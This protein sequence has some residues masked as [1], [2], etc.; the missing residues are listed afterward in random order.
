MQARRATRMAPS[1]TARVCPHTTM[2]VWTDTKSTSSPIDMQQQQQQQRHCTR[3]QPVIETDGGSTDRPAAW[4]ALASTSN[5]IRQHQCTP[6]TQQRRAGFPCPPRPLPQRQKSPVTAAAEGRPGGRREGGRWVGDARPSLAWQH[7]QEERNSIVPSHGAGHAIHTTSDAQVGGRN[8]MTATTPSFGSSTHPAP[9]RGLGPSFLPV[10]RSQALGPGRKP[11][12]VCLVR[13]SSH[14]HTH[15]T[16]SK[17]KTQDTPQ[18]GGA[19]QARVQ[20][21]GGFFALSG[22]VI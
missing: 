10:P 1:R 6:W 5:S 7:Q 21:T 3:Q 2:Y 17:N 11:G 20:I 12:R 15:T 8:N 16:K 13:A 18:P 19:R 14:T 9:D 4:T 22:S